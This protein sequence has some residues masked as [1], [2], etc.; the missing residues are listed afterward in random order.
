[1]KWGTDFA[2]RDWHSPYAKAKAVGRKGGKGKRLWWGLVVKPPSHSAAWPPIFSSRPMPTFNEFAEISCNLSNLSQELLLEQMGQGMQEAHEAMPSLEWEC[3][4][5]GHTLRGVSA[6]WQDRTLL[7][8]SAAFWGYPQCQGELGCR[9]TSSSWGRRWETSCT[10]STSGTWPL[11]GCGAKG[12]ME[13]HFS[14]RVWLCCLC[15][16][17][18]AQQQIAEGHRAL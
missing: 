5:P 8:L 1:M 2:S 4:S 9:R 10:S 11:S 3:A 15:K 18:A 13:V 7:A 6:S 17:W 16:G 12:R 14:D